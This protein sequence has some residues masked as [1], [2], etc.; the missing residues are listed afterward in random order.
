MVTPLAVDR[1]GAPTSEDF[2][3][4][5]GALDVG[6][7]RSPAVGVPLDER[8]VPVDL[9]GGVGRRCNYRRAGGFKTGGIIR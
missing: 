8:P 9:G 1:V 5:V 3:P 2:N 7:A 6:G 4:T